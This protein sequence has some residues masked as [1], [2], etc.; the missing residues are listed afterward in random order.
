MRIGIWDTNINFH[1]SYIH[2]P[3]KVELRSSKKHDK[4]KCHL[5]GSIIPKFVTPQIVYFAISLYTRNIFFCNE[6]MYLFF[7]VTNI[8]ANSIVCMLVYP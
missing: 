2:L 8:C 6:S 1:S 3:E 4:C 5:F 7:L